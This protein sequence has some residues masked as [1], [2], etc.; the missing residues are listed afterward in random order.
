MIK[1]ENNDIVDIVESYK[2]QM[3]GIF[4]EKF[5]AIEMVGSYLLSKKVI[6]EKDVKGQVDR[7]TAALKLLMNIKELHNSKHSSGKG[8]HTADLVHTINRLKIKSSKK[9]SCRKTKNINTIISK[10]NKLRSFL[11]GNDL[12]G[13]APRDHIRLNDDLKNKLEPISTKFYN[14]FFDYQK[15]YDPINNGIGKALDIKTCPYCNRNYITYIPD[16][17]NRVIGPSYDHFY[18]KSKYKYITLS[19]Y[20]LIPS[21]YICNSNLKGSVPFKLDYHIHPHLGGFSDDVVFDFNLATTDFLYNK[22]IIFA[23]LLIE[24]EN[25]SSN[26]RNRTFGDEK[27]KDSGSINIFKLNEVYSSHNDSVEEIYKRFEK[28]GAYYLG[29]ISEIIKDLGTS[30]E[31]FYRYTFRNYFNESD[32]NNRPLAKLDKDIYLKMKMIAES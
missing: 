5:L 19:F 18:S 16:K 21:C 32:F 12:F 26:K 15:Y 6:T 31:E 2:N 13:G 4:F 8:K 28:N 7:Y 3:T 22:K 1:I 29:S 17:K 30:E 23:P 9:S 11:I 24:G 14:H 20:N 25:I 10:V 27:I